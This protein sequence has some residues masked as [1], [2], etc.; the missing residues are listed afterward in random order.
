MTTFDGEEFLQ[1]GRTDTDGSGVKEG[2]SLGAR[3]GWG[4]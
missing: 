1:G 3:G 4:Q 2:G